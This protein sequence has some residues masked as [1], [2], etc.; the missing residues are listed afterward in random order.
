[1]TTVKAAAIVV[2]S[3][4]HVAHGGGSGYGVAVWTGLTTAQGAILVGSIVA[5]CIIGLCICQRNIR[6]G[7][8]W[9]RPKD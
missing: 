2:M 1:M 6:R 9:R 3:S 5:V 8:Q 7:G 4:G